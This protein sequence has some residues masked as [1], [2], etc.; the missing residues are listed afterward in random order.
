MLNKFTFCVAF[1]L[2]LSFAVH[3]K[4][5]LRVALVDVCQPH[6]TIATRDYVDAFLKGGYA[7]FVIPRMPVGPALRTLVAQADVVVF[8]GGEDVNPSYYKAVPSPQLGEV[9]DTRDGFEF[10][11]ADEAMAQKK[12]MMGIC[13]GEQFINVYFGG[14]LYQDIPTECPSDVSHRGVTHTTLIEPSSRLAKIMNVTSVVTNSFHHQAVKQLAPGFRVAA[15]ATDGTVECI[16]CDSLPVAGVQ[17][18]PEA[19]LA[20]G[21]EQWLKLFANIKLFLKNRKRR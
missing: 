3:A 2:V 6:A 9:N 1:V 16:E 18:H 4:T 5:P 14:T 13:R 10:S 19:M 7:P 15:R 12:P 17:F 21:D 11:V 8:M 20:N